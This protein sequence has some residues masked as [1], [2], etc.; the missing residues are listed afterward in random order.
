VARRCVFCGSAGVTK[1]HVIPLWVSQHIRKVN[2]DA[3]GF[4]VGGAAFPGR[5][6]VP[7]ID[8]QVKQVC[9]KCNSGWM[10]HL[11]VESR[12]LLRN[13]FAGNR[14]QLTVADQRTV[15]RWA[16]KTAMMMELLTRERKVAPVARTELYEGQVPNGHSVVLAACDPREVHGEVSYA[17]LLIDFPNG[18]AVSAYA[19][20]MTIDHLVM[21]VVGLSQI[22]GW[23][24]DIDYD[25]AVR[26][27]AAVV[28]CPASDSVATWP[29]RGRLNAEQHELFVRLPLPKD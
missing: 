5:R 12:P 11:E 27:G 16:I 3:T 15:S 25:D 10:N 1:E 24:I 7:L 2:P 4:Q 14:V 18:H 22:G 19:I 20:T 21:Q 23:V 28:I 8:L 26:A 17:P 13:F 9:G 29:P 6:H